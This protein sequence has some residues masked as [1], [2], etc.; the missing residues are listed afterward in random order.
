[1]NTVAFK[2]VLYI[3]IQ[4]GFSYA[5]KL[6]QKIKFKNNL[7]NNNLDIKWIWILKK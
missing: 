6:V 1:M 4:F 5:L 7:G 3:R 2:F